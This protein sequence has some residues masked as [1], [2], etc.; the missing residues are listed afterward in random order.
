MSRHP[1][2]Y[3]YHLSSQDLV[4]RGRRLPVRDRPD[5]R[6]EHH[7]LYQMYVRRQLAQPSL[8]HSLP[9]D[10]RFHEYALLRPVGPGFRSDPLDSRK[11]GPYD[12]HHRGLEG[13][14]RRHVVRLQA[15]P[16]LNPSRYHRL[17]RHLR[18]HRQNQK[19]SSPSSPGH[20]CR[21]RSSGRPT[22]VFVRTFA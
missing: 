19:S 17:P 12:R 21:R 9:C 20:S 22:R 15:M 11:S 10:G 7:V 8:R 1:C 5:L 3:L 14:L 16:A 18:V 4:L 2:R 13:R 6:C